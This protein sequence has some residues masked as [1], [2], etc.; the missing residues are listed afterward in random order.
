MILE[1]VPYYR[2]PRD[3]DGRPSRLFDRLFEM[4]LRWHA[5][6]EIPADMVSSA[7]KKRG[8]PPQHM[9]EV[10]LHNLRDGNDVSQRQ[11]DAALAYLRAAE[12]FYESNPWE[13]I[14]PYPGRNQEAADDFQE[15]LAELDP[16]D[17]E[18]Y[19]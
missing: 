14:E 3:D 5:E 1:T 13:G 2:I 18:L 6:I 8:D 17:T 16:F 4:A 11:L 15:L 19:R 10:A 7:S 12:A 9:G